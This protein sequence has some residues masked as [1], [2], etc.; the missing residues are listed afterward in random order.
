MKKKSP[1]LE[2]A[3]LEAQTNDKKEKLLK[4]LE[5]KTFEPFCILLFVG[6]LKNNFIKYSYLKIN[7]YAKYYIKIPSII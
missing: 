5:S 1:P 7:K 2:R 3:D 4:R 6:K